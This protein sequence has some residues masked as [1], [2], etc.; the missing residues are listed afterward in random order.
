MNVNPVLAWPGMIL[1]DM[2]GKLFIRS[3]QLVSKRLPYP[4][5]RFSNV[6]AFRHVVP[7]TRD[8]LFIAPSALVQGNVKLG[9]NCALLFHTIVRNFHGAVAT[10]IGDNTVIMDRTTFLGQVTVGNN[11]VIG[12]GCTIDM[13]TVGDDV[14]IGHGASLCYGVVVE[15]G[16]VVSAGSIVSPDT[17]VKCGELWAGNPAAKVADLT[18]EQSLER[19]QIAKDTLESARQLKQ[20]IQ[21]YFTSNTINDEWLRRVMTQVEAHHHE[22]SETREADIP[23]EAK[24]FMEPRVTMRRPEIQVRT[25]FP[26]NRMAP[27]IPRMPDWPGNT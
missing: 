18:T 24:R 20:A 17:T 22:V 12:S 25:S 23:I 3:L 6:L 10:K 2:G 5:C 13:C 21:D 16:A 15:R 1:K 27:W 19:E 11:T 14:Y 9:H 4:V 26:T 7:I 8:A